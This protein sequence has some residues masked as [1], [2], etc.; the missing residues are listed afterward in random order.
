MKENA[1]A[2]ILIFLVAFSA[3]ALLG[4]AFLHLL[5]EAILDS[6]GSGAVLLNIFLWV[7]GGFCL[8]FLLE[9]FMSWH[10]HHSLDHP[11][12]KPFS[13]LILF[14]GGLHNFLDGLTIASSFFISFPVG[15]ASTLAV[16]IHEIPHEIGDF[17]VLVYGGFT[18]GKALFYNFLSAL[19]A[20]LGGLVGYFLA[21]S[22][23]GSAVYLLPFAAGNFLYIACSDLIPE[24]KGKEGLGK[25]IFHF[26]VF[27]LGII[28][29]LILK[30]LI[31]KNA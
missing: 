13:F 16:M 25:S 28:L 4:G 3:G 23:G 31:G 1:V 19:I 10:H 22:I 8:F 2:K 11:E 26:I 20:I 7:M 18:R 6:G 30:I 29:M 27:V 14:S 24:I 21:G 15:I 9:Q 12:I 17:G 5:P